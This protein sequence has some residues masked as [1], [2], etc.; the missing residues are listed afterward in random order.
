M[1]LHLSIGRLRLDLSTEPQPPRDDYPVV[2]PT[3]MTVY[4]PDR[5]DETVGFR[6]PSARTRKEE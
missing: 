5:E 1:I 6:R 4:V 3:H 2:I